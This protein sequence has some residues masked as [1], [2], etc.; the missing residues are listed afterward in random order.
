MLSVGYDVSESVVVLEDSPGRVQAIRRVL[1][2]QPLELVLFDRAPDFV[3]WLG[4][5]LTP[6]LISLDY[7]LGH[8]AGSGLD[9]AIALAKREPLAPVILHSN[10]RHGASAQERLLADAGWTTERFSFG[11]LEWAQALRRTIG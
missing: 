8:D 9:A 4:E 5:G 2:N 1:A 7:H 6:A 10:D 11:E 3:A